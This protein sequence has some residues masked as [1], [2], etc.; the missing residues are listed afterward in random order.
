MA[1]HLLWSEHCGPLSLGRGLY[2]WRVGDRMDQ[3]NPLL[4]AV[5]VIA[6]PLLLSALNAR[7]TRRSKADDNERLDL[8]AARAEEAALLVAARQDAAA[9]RAAEAAEDLAKTN[10]LSAQAASR[11]ADAAA[12]AA[13]TMVEKLDVIHTL[14]N[15]SLTAAVQAEL[16]ATIRELAQR[17]DNMDLRRRVGE[18]PSADDAAAIAADEERIGEIRLLL[19]ERTRQQA[20]ANTQVAAAEAA[21]RSSRAEG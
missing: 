12:D 9:A 11:A 6:G 19:A 1:R 20:A 3:L 17:R 16:D 4:L 2:P 15:S 21:Q 18:E 5:L 13:S 14:V 10:R 7:Q 8:V